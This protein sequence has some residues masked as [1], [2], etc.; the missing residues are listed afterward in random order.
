MIIHKHNIQKTRH[1]LQPNST[2]NSKLF[3]LH[4]DVIDISVEK[5]RRN[6][7]KRKCGNAL[8]KHVSLM[9]QIK[10][11]YSQLLIICC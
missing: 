8:S 1:C 11:S 3:I 7:N 6:S 5:G 9:N 2:A 10:E 4:A